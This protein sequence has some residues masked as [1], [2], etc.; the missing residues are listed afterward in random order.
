MIES[1]NAAG[2]TIPQQ[3]AM[4]CR[5]LALEGFEDLTLGHVSSRGPDA[6][7]VYIKRKG[8][9]LS[10]V[11][12]EDVL[13]LRWADPEALQVPEMHLE[14][15][16]HTEVYRA[17]DDVGAVIHAHPWYAT[18]LAAVD[19]PLQMLTHD[20]VLFHEGLPVFDET[21]EMITD[22]EQ[23]KAV[24]AVLGDAR[25]LLLRNHGVLV[26][27]EDIRAAVLT[28]LTLER[29]ARMQIL[30]S[31][32]GPAVP[33]APDTLADVFRTKYQDRFLDEYWAYWRRQ[34]ERAQATGRL[35]RD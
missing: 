9:A 11:R 29:A 8:P 14:A 4:A 12:A 30:A 21:S 5:C 17:R 31:G 7:I 28:A 10:E 18:V 32:L 20:G 24:A 26:A 25:A 23:G 22:P 33:I 15:V 2:E 13:P 3:V 35:P 19:A 34:V 16:L 6:D 1:T 27:G